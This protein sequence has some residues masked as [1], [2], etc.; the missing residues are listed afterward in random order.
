MQRREFI[1]GLGSAAMVPTLSVAQQPGTPVIGILTLGSRES[2]RDMLA[3]FSRGLRSAGYVEGRT[4]TIEYRG[5]EG[6]GDGLPTLAAELVQRQVTMIVAT[7][8]LAVLTAKAATS[9][10]PIVF[11]LGADPVKFGLVASLNQPG[12][13]ATGV[14]FL[15]NSMMSKQFEILH[16]T[17]PRPRSSASW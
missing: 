16:L 15:V 2:R 1:A 7:G 14:S 9:T 13:N 10:I 12:G 8:T 11:A 5:A 4:V 17:V 3:A 6:R